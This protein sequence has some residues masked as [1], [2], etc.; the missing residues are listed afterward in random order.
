MKKALLLLCLHMMVGSVS[1]Q[2]ETRTL[3]YNGFAFRL[4]N[5]M[6]TEAGEQNV[7]CSPLS[8][9]LAMNMQANGAAGNTLQEI[10]QV[11][12][13]AGQSLDEVNIYNAKLMQTMARE[14]KLTEKDKMYAFT[15]ESLPIVAFANGIWTRVSLYDSFIKTNQT[16]YDAEVE[17]DVNFGLQETMDAI[18]TWVSEK[19]HGTIP[20][21]N[22]DPDPNIAS[23]LINALYF[24]GQWAVPF[25]TGATWDDHFRNADGE[26]ALVP[27]MHL[28]ETFPYAELRSCKAVRLAYATDGEF[29]MTLFLPNEEAEDFQ[30]TK[31]LWNEAQQG[32]KRQSVALSMP[33]FTVDTETDLN[34]VLQSMGLREAFIYGV[35]D[36]SRMSP[37][38]LYIDLIKQLCHVAVDEKGTEASA[39]TVIMSEETAIPQYK[40]FEAN[41]PF[42][43]TIE[44]NGTGTVLFVGEINELEDSGNLMTI[45]EAK[46]RKT[47]KENKDILYDLQGRALN[48]PPAKGIYIQDGHKIV[49]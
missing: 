36:F 17:Q 3:D 31:D 6:K 14:R 41:R 11:F 32:M 40:K 2:E 45:E 28:S 13:T 48:S 18:D 38:E 8:V 47:D 37:N 27:M 46:F 29:S 10:Q 21:I 22:E 26:D 33:R 30:L 1:A 24:K 39:V 5:Q 7:V 19:T 9:E 42:C 23:I 16:Y 12:G 35:A 20:S 49:K 44:D 15:E 34:S 43:F 4:F 25:E